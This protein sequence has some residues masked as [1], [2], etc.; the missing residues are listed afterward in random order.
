MKNIFITKIMIF[1]V[2]CVT[3]QVAMSNDHPFW[4]TQD[5]VDRKLNAENVRIS[6]ATF[7]AGHTKIAHQETNG[8]LDRYRD[9]RGS[10][11][12]ALSHKSNGMVKLSSFNSM[13]HALKSGKSSDFNDIILGD[14][15]H[16]VDPQAAYAYALEG[17][18]AAAYAIPKPPKLTS[19]EIAGEMVELYWQALL[20]DV[21]FNQYNTNP[22]AAAAI[23][24]LNSLSKFKGPK[25]GGLVTPQTLFRSV[26][27]GEL[28]GPYISQFLYKP[29]PDHGRLVQ[30]LYYFYLPGTANNFL[31]NVN[32]FLLV[33]NGGSTG[34]VDVFQASPNYIF[35]GRDLGTYV[36]KDYPTEAWVNAALILL[37]FGTPALDPNNPY[38]TNPT[39]D[40][41]VTYGQVKVIELV[42]TA[43]AAALKAC[44]Y[45]KWMVHLRLRPEFFGFLVQDQIV[46]GAD[47]DLNSDVINSPVLADIF[48]LY[49]T[50]LLPQMYPEG[51]P[52]HPS[53]PAG[54]AVISGA[55]A[56]ILKAFF[57]EDFVIPAPVQ[58]NITNTGFDPYGGVL[59]VGD[60]LNKLAGNIGMGRDFAGIH[61]RS[62]EIE[63]MKLGED[64]ALSILRDEAYTN[65]ESFKGFKLTKFNGEKIVIG[66]KVKVEKITI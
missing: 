22:V 46:N 30:Q 1:S 10:F 36:H 47:F 25:I 6:D 17:A 61:Y 35:T 66:K 58:P 37:G 56:T 16:L 41:F 45:Q 49:G 55:C 18:D 5:L 8:D 24:D 27:P 31:T 23:A 38:K 32:D 44:W 52:T 65:N 62:D 7:E 11:S 39:Q 9:K 13:I 20:R 43:A 29:I 42:N 2:V 51:S 33:N 21:P 48:G 40:G 15:R 53:Y 59:L 64:I 26:T 4:N 60:E 28:V 57:D 19:A 14:G 63:G 34:Q 50:Y 54:H 3:S 12:K